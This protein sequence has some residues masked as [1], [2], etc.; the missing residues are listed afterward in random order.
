MQVDAPQGPFHQSV[1][2]DWHG[3]G[4][5]RLRV[6]L[7]PPHARSHHAAVPLHLSDSSDEALDPDGVLMTEGAI[8]GA[9][10]RAAR[11]CMAHDLRS[12]RVELK[13][14]INVQDE[15]GEIVH[16]VHFADAVTI[17]AP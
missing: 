4:R 7:L 11:D 12:G 3:G 14:R 13:Y 1:C 10:L 5:P 9:A 15:A 8:A 17:V 6:G 2:I 16:T